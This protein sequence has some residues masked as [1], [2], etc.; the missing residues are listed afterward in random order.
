MEKKILL[1][2][3]NNQ[4]FLVSAMGKKIEEAGYSVEYSTPEK[5]SFRQE[6]IVRIFSSFILKGTWKD[7][8]TY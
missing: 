2:C 1:I 8:K 5:N 6:Q 7:L 4:N 3:V